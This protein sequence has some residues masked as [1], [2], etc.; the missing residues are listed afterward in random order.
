MLRLASSHKSPRTITKSNDNI[1]IYSRIEATNRQTNTKT[2]AQDS[3]A[4]T[5]FK[6]KCQLK[7]N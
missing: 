4:Q 3:V 1:H 2:N 6:F 7:F 5:L